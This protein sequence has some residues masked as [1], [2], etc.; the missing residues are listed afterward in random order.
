M[1]TIY[2]KAEDIRSVAEATFTPSSTGL[3]AVTGPNGAG[4]S[5]L[6]TAIPLLAGWG[7]TPPGTGNLAAI[8]R[9]GAKTGTVEWAFEIG[10]VEYVVTRTF[11]RT[12]A[13]ASTARATLTI[14]GSDKTTTGLKPGDITAEITRI[15][16]MRPDTWL[17]TS[18]IAQSDVD[19]L[20]SASPREVRDRIRDIL[21]LRKIDSAADAMSAEIRAIDLPDAPD[22]ATLAMLKSRADDTAARAAQA[23]VAESEATTALTQSQTSLAEMEQKLATLRAQTDAAESSRSQHSAAIIRRNDAEAALTRALGEYSA[24]LDATG[25]GWNGAAEE[26]LELATEQVQTLTYRQSRA[27]ELSVIAESETADID[28]LRAVLTE[29]TRDKELTDRELATAAGDDFIDANR[30]RASHASSLIGVLEAT[31]SALAGEGT[32]PTCGTHVGHADD[33]TARLDSQIADLRA[34]EVEAL[35]LVNQAVAQRNDIRTRVAAAERA[36]TAASHALA[37]AERGCQRILDAREELD[38][39]GDVSDLP[40]RIQIM[41]AV[42]DTAS[43]VI[44]TRKQYDDAAGAVDRIEIVEPP[45]AEL[46][47]KVQTGYT[48]WAEKVLTSRDNYH[49]AAALLREVAPSAQACRTEWEQ[50]QARFDARAEAEKQLGEKSAA[51]T[52]LKRF[53]AAYTSEKVGVIT[54]AVNRLLPLTAGEFTDFQLDADFAPTVNYAGASRSTSDLSG[55]ERS[56][57]GLL[58]RIGVTAAMSGGALTGT[59][60]ADEP[61]A[62][63]DSQARQRVT[64]LLSGLPVPVVLVSH[65]PEAAEVA[66]VTANVHRARFGTTEVSMIVAP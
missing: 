37:E 20:M 35:D 8:I 24:A 60:I 31:R 9:D 62:A 46:V 1:R 16:G 65:T 36:V 43:E 55:G 59:I 47:E 10:G 52:L 53:T 11:R 7:Q 44:R 5:T 63:L 64:S 48:E 42:R 61:L 34:D 58:F 4:K 22:A 2:T 27:A 12:K 66:A 50:A 23:Q 25:S 57:L 49:A 13:G 14:D 39:L 19:A 41:T 32:C 18:L 33:L 30:A 28:A 51:A 38:G 40:S 21:G 15:T 26:G 3:T 56:V 54:D 17:S 6:T 29:A 45:A